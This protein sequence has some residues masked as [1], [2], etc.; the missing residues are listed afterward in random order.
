MTIA[1]LQEQHELLCSMTKTNLCHAMPP[2]FIYQPTHPGEGKTLKG[3]KTRVLNACVVH[4]TMSLQAIMIKFVETGW[5]TKMAF[6]TSRA[7]KGH[8]QMMEWDGAVQGRQ[9]RQDRTGKTGQQGGAAG[10]SRAG[11]GCVGKTGPGKAC[12]TG[13]SGAYTHPTHFLIRR[14]HLHD[15]PVFKLLQAG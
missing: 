5:P 1:A 15:C 4:H 10:E 7:C 13:Q 6:T 14:V 2:I 11:E 9:G 3:L 12:G 8:D